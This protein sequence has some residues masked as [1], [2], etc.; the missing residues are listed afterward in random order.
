VLLAGAAA[1]VHPSLHEGFGLTPLEAMYAGVPVIAARSPGL[2]E[3]C[4]DAALYFDPLDAEELAQALA[5]VVA[6]REL[7]T[8]LAARGTARAAEFSWSASA[9]A[10]IAAYTLAQH[11]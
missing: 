11:G 5:R 6:D 8:G 3:T 1:L 2:T 10:H 7:S 4:A 9:R